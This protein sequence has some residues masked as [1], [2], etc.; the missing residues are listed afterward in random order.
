MHAAVTSVTVTRG[1]A[2]G[3][4]VLDWA[5]GFG[6]PEIIER[7]DGLIELGAGPTGYLAAFEGWPVAEQQALAYLHGRVLDVGCGAG[8]VANHLQACGHDVVGIDS[9]KLAVQASRE[10]GL[11]HARVASIDDVVDMLERFDSLLLFGNNLG[12]FGTPA[13]ATRLLSAWSAVAGAE[14][15]IFV[16]ST[17][18]LSGGAPVIDRRYARRNRER[19]TPTG[20]VRMRIWYDRMSTDWVPWFFAARSELR[21]IVEGT[22]WRVATVLGTERSEPYVAILELRP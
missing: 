16:E 7:D 1:D 2:F 15:R 17:D 8:R 6:D 5:R 9:S 12:V 14:T 20:Q 19:G 18:P 22:G 3:R 10:L 4:A 13:R 21:H 11:R